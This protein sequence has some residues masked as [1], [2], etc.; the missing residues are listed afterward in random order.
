[1][2]PAYL[3]TTFIFAKAFVFPK[4][5]M[6]LDI[7][8]TLTVSVLTIGLMILGLALFENRRCLAAKLLNKRIPKI[9]MMV[10]CM[11]LRLDKYSL[12]CNQDIF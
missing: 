12:N 9:R 4:R 10:K 8:L 6:V 3:L 11:F 2:V 5:E 7:G 1:M